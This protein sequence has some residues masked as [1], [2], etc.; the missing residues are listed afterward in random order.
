MKVLLVNGVGFEGGAERWIVHLVRQLAARGHTMEVAHHPD[1][2]LG[3][4]AAAAGASSFVPS[5]GFRGVLRTAASLARAIR[6]GGHDVVV[7]T[8][9]GDL[10]PAGLAAR[11]AG[12]PG[13]V[14]RLF[15]GWA[16]EEEAVASGPR[17]WR[18]RQY[19]RR[20]VHLGA[21]NSAAGKAMIL[22]R[23]F[24]PPG[25][26]EVIYN[27]L[28]TARF[29]PDAVES[30]AFRRELGIAPDTELVVSISRFAPRKGQRYELEAA[31]RLC[32]DRPS[33]HVA[34][35]GP[36]DAGDAGYRAGLVRRATAAP[37]ADRIT[38]LG[39][40]P[41]VPAILADA[42][43][44]LRA[45]L[46]EGLPN[47]ALEAMAMRTPVIATGICGTPEA[48]LDGRTGRLVPHGD[49]DA[50][51]AAVTALLDAPADE[52]EAMGRRGR[53]HVTDRFSLERMADAYQALF[54]RAL[55]ERNS[56]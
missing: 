42:D 4:R 5:T 56:L 24:L 23:D 36:C 17:W 41:D 9:R 13:V 18:H 49:S 50:I 28:D 47:I 43:L 3:E 8:S 20:L 37:V 12:H 14:A 30:G 45:A 38:F 35:I 46:T 22:A 53:R 16:P 19:H 21:T 48:V 1:S 34:F 32:A 25:R 40:R 33:L 54:E 26:I 10:K 27:G 15:S 11:L 31:L 39:A 44:L 7:S 52:R 55:R 2:R 29:D 51:V 6:Q